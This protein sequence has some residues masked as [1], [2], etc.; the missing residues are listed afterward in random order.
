MGLRWSGEAVMRR[1][2]KKKRKSKQ[3]IISV[4]N[5]TL[6]REPTV[7]FC[8]THTQT[9]TPERHAHTC[10]HVRAHTQKK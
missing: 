8:C 3:S 9:H 5:K 4:L 7:T 1:P 2:G 6:S 10:V